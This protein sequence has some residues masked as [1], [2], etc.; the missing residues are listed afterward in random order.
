MNSGGEGVMLRKPQSAYENGRSHSLLKYKTVKDD[1]GLV[2]SVQ[3]GRNYIC[4]LRNGRLF[5]AR[6]KRSLDEVI[7]AGDLVTFTFPH[8]SPVTGLPV[9]ALIFKKRDDLTWDSIVV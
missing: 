4:Q 8:T 3:R 2:L 1:E 9:D 5:T 7:N 6:K